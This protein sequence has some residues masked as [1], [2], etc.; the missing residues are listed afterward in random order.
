MIHESY[1]SFADNLLSSKS[2]GTNNDSPLEA[3]LEI[4][5]KCNLRCVHCYIGD[6]RWKPND[7]ELSTKEWK[8]IIDTLFDMGTLWITF[9]GGEPL[10]R[11]D[12]PE[13]WEYAAHKGFLLR[14]YSNA[15]FYNEKIH[16]LFQEYPPYRVEVSFYGSNLEIFEQVTK[17]K[18]QYQKFL[19]GLQLLKTLQIPLLLKIPGIQ[20][21]KNDIPLML[22]QAKEWNIPYLLETLIQPSIGSG[23]SAGLSPCS[24]RLTEEEAIELE[25]CDPI[26]KQDYINNANLGKEK[27]DDVLYKCGAGKN[28]IYITSTG[29]LQACTMTNH[30]KEAP[31]LNKN[32]IRES[33]QESWK[34]LQSI[35]N[36][37]RDKNSPCYSCDLNE[38]CRSCPGLSQLENQDEQSAT[39]WA[40]RH[41]HMKA[42][43]LKIPHKCDIHHPVNKYK[44]I[45]NSSST[46]TR[47]DRL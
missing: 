41:T 37:K 26:A 22:Q 8:S 21:T 19:N 32:K 18:G 40:C 7:L 25:L 33:F 42:H 9:S 30:R 23:T 11:E 35:Q 31:N 2:S 47:D 5:G 20:Q 14:L 10:L 13:L 4:S 16:K 46:K 39:Y 17:M 44:K 24:T 6:H 36:I 45:K 34:K 29:N 27:S 15:V 1:Y 3:T 38:I 43:I 12:F 28:E